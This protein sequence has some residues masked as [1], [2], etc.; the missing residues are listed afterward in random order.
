MSK[1]V[2]ISRDKEALI[3]LQCIQ[4]A[5]CKSKYSRTNCTL[6]TTPRVCAQTTVS[7][8]AFAVRDKR[9]DNHHEKKLFIEHHANHEHKQSLMLLPWRYRIDWVG[10]DAWAHKN[11]QTFQCFWW[12][13]SIHICYRSQKFSRGLRGL[14]DG[15]PTGTDEFSEKFQMAIDLPPS[16]SENHIA[17]F[18]QSPPYS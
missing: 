11:S 18:L 12:G 5:S 9:S 2:I 13:K 1:S 3:P 16:F 15:W 7:P 14:R 17:I 8:T 4:K 10:V 6:G